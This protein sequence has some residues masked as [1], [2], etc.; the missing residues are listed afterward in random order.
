MV[1]LDE[2]DLQR[3][4]GAKF[5]RQFS[6]V[7]FKTVLRFNREAEKRGFLVVVG[8]GA[9]LDRVFSR[10]SVFKT[11]DFDL[12]L[13]P[14]LLERMPPR[15]ELR[16]AALVL[17]SD[18]ETD[19]SDFSKG[20]EVRTSRSRI[21]EDLDGY[22]CSP[23]YVEQ[24]ASDTD[25]LAASIKYRFITLAD[26][27][28]V[29]SYI[30]TIVDIG[31]WDADL[32]LKNH[33][34]GGRIS[35]AEALQFI[36]LGQLPLRVIWIKG[37]PYPSL[38][39]MLW[40][41]LRMVREHGKKFNVYVQK[42][43]ALLSSFNKPETHL[44]SYMR[45]AICRRKKTKEVFLEP[46]SQDT[47]EAEAITVF[48]AGISQPPQGDK[49][50]PAQISSPVKIAYRTSKTEQKILER[51]MRF[52]GKEARLS[53]VSAL[54]FHFDS[55]TDMG[56]APIFDYLPKGIPLLFLEVKD[57]DSRRLIVDQILS[58]NSLEFKDGIIY[59]NSSSPLV[60]VA[61][62]NDLTISR[63]T[64]AVFG[65]S[66]KFNNELEAFARR[67]ASRAGTT[68]GNWVAPLGLAL[69]QLVLADYL[70]LLAYSC[71]LLDYPGYLTEFIFEPFCN[72]P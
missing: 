24:G 6:S 29:H 19:L 47:D 68:D 65:T 48:F 5:R 44:R 50:H 36:R 15:K 25:V 43:L 22:F 46:P 38:G 39:E 59:S 21:V 40:D 23:F 33:T 52:L 37:L 11:A 54:E 64:Q 72:R 58:K 45:E 51:A 3:Q 57:E 8:G 32:I 14:L 13:V 4:E 2:A 7:I 16:Q 63:D 60:S 70:E 26:D 9:A 55:A 12:K 49:H 18:I 53:S 27:N 35:L 66:S 17:A 10:E 62:V 41:T 30:G 69:H 67:S 28:H 31:L 20:A 42:Y 56:V 61:V 71:R 1:A 34:L